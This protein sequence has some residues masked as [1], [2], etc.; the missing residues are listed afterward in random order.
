MYCGHRFNGVPTSGQ[1][2]IK[3]E[4]LPFPKIEKFILSIIFQSKRDPMRLQYSSMKERKVN[5]IGHLK[6]SCQM[7]ILH[8]TFLHVRP[9]QS[10]VPEMVIHDQ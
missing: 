7:R 10:I 6:Y 3:H 9:R 8:E 5:I 4:I 2:L 1:P